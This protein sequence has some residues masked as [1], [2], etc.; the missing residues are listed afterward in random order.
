MSWRNQRE[1]VSGAFSVPFCSCLLRYRFVAGYGT[2]S[3]RVPIQRLQARLLQLQLV[4][5][6]IVHMP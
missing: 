3:I 5:V 2:P 4:R 1:P 6:V